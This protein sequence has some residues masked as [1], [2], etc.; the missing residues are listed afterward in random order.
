MTP[1]EERN[2]IYLH[3]VPY[4]Y[5]GFLLMPVQVFAFMLNRAILGF[6]IT[7]VIMALFLVY[8][9][10]SYHWTFSGYKKKKK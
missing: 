10:L 5:V 4:F 6:I 1:I 8:A 3:S 7:A 2:Q 9:I